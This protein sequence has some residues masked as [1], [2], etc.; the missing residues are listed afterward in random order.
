MEI[1]EASGDRLDGLVD[2]NESLSSLRGIPVS[3]GETGVSPVIVSIGDNASRYRVASKLTGKFGRAIHPSAIVSPT[4]TIGEGTVV[5]QGAIIQAGAIIGKH[6]IV[7][8]G[9]TIDHECVLEDFVHVS[10]HATLCGNARVGEGS[11]I[12]AGTTIIPGVRVGR[13][14]VIGA[15]SVVTRGIPGNVVAFGNKC[16]VMGDNCKRMLNG[17]KID[18]AVYGAG[19]FGREVLSM[20]EELNGK[21]GVFNPVGY[22]DD[23]LKAGEPVNGHEV[24]GGMSELNAYPGPLALV[25]ALGSPALKRRIVGAIDNPGVFF[26]SVVD[27]TALVSD[28]FHVTMGKGCVVC[29]GTMITT[30]VRLG[31]FVILNLGCTVGHDTIVGSYSSF[32][33]SVNISGEV[34]I[35]EGVYAGTGAK[36]I[37]RLEIG[38][39]TVVGAGAVVTSSLPSRCTA[40]GVPAKPVKFFD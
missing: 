9:A 40:V 37:N 27:L 10:P 20:L 17:G 13:W 14:S 22:F 15:G 12:G 29:G 19:G 31:D 6:C 16:V 28:P 33:P 32:M 8:T 23:G 36:I 35:G 11:W 21:T 39:G 4:A 7:N 2:D 24:L 30:N 34:T 26:P 25:V 5:M 1:L 38:A 3:H 18:V